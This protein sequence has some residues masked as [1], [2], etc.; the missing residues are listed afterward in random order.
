VIA[1]GFFLL[2][3]GQTWAASL[4]GVTFDSIGGAPQWTNE[5]TLG[6][7]NNLRYETGVNSGFSLTTRVTGG[8]A[9]NPV[10]VGAATIPMGDANL[11][12]IDGNFYGFQTLTAD[13]SH[14]KARQAY[15]VWVFVARENYPTHQGVSI[16]GAGTTTFMQLDSSPRQL[17]VNSNVGSSSEDLSY[18]ALPIVSNAAGDITIDVENMDDGYG[19]AISGIAVMAV[20][21]PSTWAMML[22][23]FAGLGYAARRKTKRNH[24]ALSQS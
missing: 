7:T 16:T 14:L 12:G 1:A 9:S 18:Y 13:L 2:G 3:A 17:I 15:D 5:T 10:T 11:S 22:V 23:G 4:V 8:L 19:A 21:E 6:T 24:A 20:P